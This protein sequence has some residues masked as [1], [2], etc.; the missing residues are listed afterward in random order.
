MALRFSEVDPTDVGRSCLV[1]GLMTVA[2]ICLIC[3]TMTIRLKF[4]KSHR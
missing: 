1:L 2:S 4:T 3:E